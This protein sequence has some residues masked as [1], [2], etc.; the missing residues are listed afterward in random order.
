MKY[1][2]II[3]DLGGTLSRSAAWEDYRNA[4][5]QVAQ[6]CGAPADKFLELWF[7]RSAGLGTGL[8]ATYQDYI[9]YICQLMDLDVSESLLNRAA[10]YPFSITKKQVATPREGA[11]E[12]LDYLKS[13]G[14]KLGLISDCFHDV[15]EIWN[16]TPFARYFNVTVFSCQVGINKADSRIYKIAL[17]KLAVKPE[18]CIYIADGMRNEL[19]NATV[20][21]MQA[22][23]LYIP[24]EIDD[25]PIREN[26]QG[27][28]ISSLQEV[29]NLLQ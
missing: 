6:I 22:I 21:G 29:L 14:Y 8:Y 1:Q 11:I 20:L 10:V 12:I 28:K 17:E 16:E 23:Q 25:S 2:A 18:N 26:W 13:H 4:A 9:R 15:P 3:F 7:A 27:Q 24:E 5:R 19:A